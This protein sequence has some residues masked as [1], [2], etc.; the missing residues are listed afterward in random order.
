VKKVLIGT[1]FLVAN[2]LATDMY[3]D[4]SSQNVNFKAVDLNLKGA[5]VSFNWGTDSRFYL[6]GNVQQDNSQKINYYDV[7]VGINNDIVKRN[8][9]R[10]GWD[11]GL[12]IGQLDVPW[13]SNKNTLLSVPLGCSLEY[14]ITNNL[15]FNAGAG[16][17]YFFDLTDNKE[18]TICNDGT[19]SD[20][21][22]SGTCSWHG[23]VAGTAT[24]NL[25]GNGGGISTQVGLTFKF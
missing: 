2:S 13:Y 3:V 17:K 19:I 6:K 20:S 11:I 21:S 5:T 8:N 15:A 23:G 24:N 16:Y 10:L 18:Y 22:G 25:I 14:Q 1:L 7:V 9:F 4:Y 12:G